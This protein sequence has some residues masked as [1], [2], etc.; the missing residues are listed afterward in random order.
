MSKQFKA[1]EQEELCKK[2]CELPDDM[3][4]LVM[5][6]YKKPSYVLFFKHIYKPPVWAERANGA[7]VIHNPGKQYTN[8]EDDPKSYLSSPWCDK[9]PYECYSWCDPSILKVSTGKVLS[10]CD[11]EKK[12]IIK[13]TDDY[14]NYKNINR[15]CKH[16]MKM[17]RE[18]IKTIEYDF[19]NY[20]NSGNF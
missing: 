15:H 4:K 20:G 9:K 8:A 18:A 2:V 12:H 10:L 17:M 14:E 3:V 16:N 7:F 5:S 13:L 19:S 6:F 11:D 1:I